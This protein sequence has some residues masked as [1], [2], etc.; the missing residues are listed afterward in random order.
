MGAEK[1]VKA[2]QTGDKEGKP[3]CGH[4]SGRVGGRQTK[5]VPP[6]GNGKARSAGDKAGKPPQRTPERQGQPATSRVSPPNGHLHR[7]FSPCR[8]RLR[9]GD[10]RGEAPCI[11]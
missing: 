10:A 7:R 6:P 9:R 3:P 8:L 1:K 5:Q 4:H 11:K 2:G